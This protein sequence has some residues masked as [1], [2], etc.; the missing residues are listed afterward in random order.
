VN[1]AGTTIDPSDQY[2]STAAQ[3]ARDGL[4]GDAL[5]AFRGTQFSQFSD[6][7]SLPT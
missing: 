3:K 7:A 5:T 4:I 1:V 6:R 2:Q